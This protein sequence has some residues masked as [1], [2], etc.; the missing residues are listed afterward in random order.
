MQHSVWAAE[1]VNQC[2]Q[3]AALVAAAG[4]VVAAHN[5]PFDRRMLATE[6]AAAGI[7][8]HWGDGLDTLRVT[9]CAGRR[10]PFGVDNSTTCL[11]LAGQC[12]RV[13]GPQFGEHTLNVRFNEIGLPIAMEYDLANG[14]DEESFMDM[15]FTPSP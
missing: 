13:R 7:D 14:A 10:R 15:T 4:A 8:V 12:Q 6:F 1:A 5:L 3:I 2:G 11:L 9:G